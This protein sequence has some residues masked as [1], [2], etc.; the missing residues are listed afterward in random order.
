MKQLRVG[1]VSRNYF[2]LPLWLAQAAG[3]FEAEGLDVQL[4]L[5]EGIDL[6]S[7][8]LAGG[9]LDLALNVTENSVLNREQGG[10]LQIIGGNVNR[11]PFS[12][13]GR[14]GLRS[15][16]DLKGGRIGVSSI[17]AGSSSLVMRLL[18]DQ[19]LHTP[20]DYTLLA[21]GPILAR[22]EKLRAGE[23]DA[24]LQGAPLNYIAVDAGYVDLGNPRKTFPDFQFTSL[25]V[26]RD[27]A[28]HHPDLAI[29]FLRA[30]VRAHQLFYAD[31][32]AACQ[33]ACE[34]TGIERPYAERAWL[35]Y[36]TE[37]IFPRDARASEAAV[38][39][40]IEVSGLIRELPTRAAMTASAYIDHSLIDAAHASLRGA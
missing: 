12:F 5:I 28:R 29:R 8:R 14:P 9:D 37:A 34:Q 7:A 39:T 3:Y 40:L 25:D 19:G 33:V 17:K 27:W 35:E 26:R 32:D 20:E 30:F 22:W 2:N 36:T 16:H 21:V 1:A 13:I 10:D 23:I 24:G 38:Q 15:L 6:V 11:L 18:A 31:Q 4:E